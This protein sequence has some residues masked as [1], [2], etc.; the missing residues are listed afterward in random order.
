MGQ[1]ITD[2]DCDKVLESLEWIESDLSDFIESKLPANLLGK[3]R[4]KVSDD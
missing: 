4:V 1:E 2:K 3:L